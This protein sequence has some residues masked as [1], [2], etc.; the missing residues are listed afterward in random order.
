MHCPVSP[1]A[2]YHR[3]RLV[4]VGLAETARC[5]YCGAEQVRPVATRDPPQYP[6]RASLLATAARRT[7]HLT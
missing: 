2:G 6:R 1:E 3:R 7:L 5:V 4:A